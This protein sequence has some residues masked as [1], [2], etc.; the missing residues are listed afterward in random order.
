MAVTHL[1]TRS[2]ILAEVGMQDTDLTAGVMAVVGA[3]GAIQ[4][5]I[6]AAMQL[7]VAMK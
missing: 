2:A 4:A 7:T 1:A 3:E 6:Q 5:A